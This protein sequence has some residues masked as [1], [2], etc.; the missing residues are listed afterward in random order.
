MVGLFF[1]GFAAVSQSDRAGHGASSQ[2]GQGI[3]SALFYA[4][5]LLVAYRYS[6]I[7]LRVVCIISSFF[8]TI[9]R[10]EI[11]GIQSLVCLAAYSSARSRR[12]RIRGSHSYLY[13]R[14]KSLTRSQDGKFR[15]EFFSCDVIESV[16]SCDHIC[17]NCIRH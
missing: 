3:T 8:D 1:G 14:S 16:R 2:I 5:G 9:G 13:L 11:V 7:G 4:F 6:V 17:F 15:R 10:D 12:Y